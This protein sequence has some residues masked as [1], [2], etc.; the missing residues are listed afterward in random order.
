MPIPSSDEE[1]HHY[2]ALVHE[3]GRLI[4]EEDATMDEPEEDDIDENE[5]GKKKKD[6][7]LV[8]LSRSVLEKIKERPMTTG[9]QIANEI[10]ELYK[11]FSAVSLKFCFIAF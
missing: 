11:R 6:K 3:Q 4:E 10:L 5:G 8:F 1:Q 2:R 7:K 9:T